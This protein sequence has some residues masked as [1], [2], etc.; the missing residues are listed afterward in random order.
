LNLSRPA[1]G[2]DKT[3]NGTAP[4]HDKLASSG[5]NWKKLKAPIKSYLTDLITVSHFLVEYYPK[6]GNRFPNLLFFFF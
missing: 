6:K 5:S 2:S 1:K 3:N 4:T